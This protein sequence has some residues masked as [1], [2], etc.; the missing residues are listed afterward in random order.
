MDKIKKRVPDT[1]HLSRI[2]AILVAAHQNEAFIKNLASGNSY[3]PAHLNPE[4]S[5]EMG[6]SF[7]QVYKKI[8]LRLQ[9]K[10]DK[11]DKD[12]EKK[13]ANEAAAQPDATEALIRGNNFD[14]QTDIMETDSD[15]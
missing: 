8:N 2:R 13:G 5:K 6:T 10:L 9:R 15:E 12:A 11:A 4:G 14:Q 3:V 1:E 7:T